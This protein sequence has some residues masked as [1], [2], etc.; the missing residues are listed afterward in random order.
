MADKKQPGLSEIH[1]NARGFVGRGVIYDVTKGGRKRVRFDLCC[2][3]P[4]VNSNKYP[5]WRYCVGYGDELVDSV[6]GA[7]KGSWLRVQGWLSAECELDENGMK[8]FVD[9]RPKLRE[10]LVLH[11]A[12]LLAVDSVDRQLALITNN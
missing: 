8:I 4:P 12:E 10:T 2:G 3:N 6:R 5:I 7:G 11:K 9:G 1:E